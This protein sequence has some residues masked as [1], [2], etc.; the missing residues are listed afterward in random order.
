MSATKQ[1]VRVRACYLVQVTWIPLANAYIIAINPNTQ[2]R[3]AYVTQPFT[4]TPLLALL[5]K[6][7]FSSKNFF[8]SIFRNFLTF[9]YNMI[10]DV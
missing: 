3:A 7:T 5:P 8:D 10:Q 4:R 2:R 6:Q 9:S 1:V